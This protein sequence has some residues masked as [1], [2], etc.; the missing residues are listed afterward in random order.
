MGPWS[1]IIDTLTSAGSVGTLPDRGGSTGLLAGR[2]F[3][4]WQS[5]PSSGDAVNFGSCPAAACGAAVESADSDVLEVDESP[6]L[7][8]PGSSSR[9]TT[10]TTP[11][12]SNT[13]ATAPRIISTRRCFRAA[14]ARCCNCCSRLR[15]AAARR[16]EFVG[17]GGNLLAR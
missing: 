12:I 10:N 7:T 15:L 3:G 16:S 6:A 17:T 9:R 11:T 13:A 14:S 1:V 8:L 5:A 4:Y 2:A